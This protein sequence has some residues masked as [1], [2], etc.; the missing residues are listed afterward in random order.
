MTIDSTQFDDF[1]A[2]LVLPIILHSRG[3]EG[4]REGEMYGV[5]PKKGVLKHIGQHSK[6]VWRNNI[7]FSHIVNQMFVYMCAKF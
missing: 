6:T 4:S 3:G 7:I 5:S 1:Q 2:I